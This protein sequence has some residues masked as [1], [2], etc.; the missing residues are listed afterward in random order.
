[1]TWA[2]IT[3]ALKGTH[4]LQL[5]EGSHRV[6]LIAPDPENREIYCPRI[7]TK[8][9]A[10][11]LCDRDTNERWRNA[12]NLYR[13]MRLDPKTKSSAGWLL[14]PPFYALCVTGT[15]FQIYQMQRTSGGIVNDIF[16]NVGYTKQQTLIL[17]PQELVS[18]DKSHPINALKPDHYYQ[19]IHGT[20]PSFIYDPMAP[21]ITM[22]QV[23]DGEKHSV[24]ALGISFLLKLVK[25][26]QLPVPKLRFVVVVPEGDQVHLMLPK[27]VDVPIELFSLEVSE[28]ELFP[29]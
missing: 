9:V 15:T 5:D 27:A 16:T 19:P 13:S 14:E 23:I 25:R 11:M 22:L 21:C 24:N 4:T 26:L 20:Q 29:Y 10:S 8:A 3:D 18:F 12:H 7:I 2:T 28:A 1:M 6:I 17:P